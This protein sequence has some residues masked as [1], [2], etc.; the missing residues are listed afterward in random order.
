MNDLPMTE[1]ERK[2]K[3][4]ESNKKERM[5]F[6]KALENSNDKPLDDVIENN[7]ESISKMK[8]KG[9]LMNEENKLKKL[10]Q[11]A[12][13]SSISKD[14]YNIQNNL[15]QNNNFIKLFILK[16]N[17]SYT[18]KDL[19]KLVNVIAIFLLDFFENVWKYQGKIEKKDEEKIVKKVYCYFPYI[20]YRFSLADNQINMLICGHAYHKKCFQLQDN[21][22]ILLLEDC[23]LN[24][25][26]ILNSKIENNQLNKRIAAFVENSSHFESINLSDKNKFSYTSHNLL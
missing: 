13:E 5:N 18:K 21:S 23:D 12:K 26:E 17:Y 2:K 10:F 15:Q 16:H 8:V 4:I 19:D 11:I 20:K 24:K 1:V 3:L 25:A 6:E 14:D 22:N 9:K 7:T